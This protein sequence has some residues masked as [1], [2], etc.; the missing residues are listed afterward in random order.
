[1]TIEI[2]YGIRSINQFSYL[3]RIFEIR[4]NYGIAKTS[5]FGDIKFE[6]D[7]PVQIGNR[8]KISVRPE[9]IVVSKHPPK[10]VDDNDNVLKGVVDADSGK[11]YFP[12]QAL[13]KAVGYSV[14]QA[15]G[16]KKLVLRESAIKS[17][18]E[19]KEIPTKLKGQRG[20]VIYEES[21]P[22][23]MLRFPKLRDLTDKFPKEELLKRIKQESSSHS[24][25]SSVIFEQKELKINDSGNRQAKINVSN[26]N[27][28]NPF[29]LLMANTLIKNT[30]E[31]DIT[32]G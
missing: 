2:L 8:I 17:L 5:L 3:C 29:L 14:D 18:F 6:L 31:L 16:F 7:K 20:W 26:S 24:I 32:A 30:I 12:I 25:Q 22:N 23:L 19:F 4:E 13:A 21:L 27:E 1:L 15:K 28:V 11:I 9:K 10:F